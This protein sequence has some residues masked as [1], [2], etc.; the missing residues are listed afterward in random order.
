[1]QALR[2]GAASS[3]AVEAS[4]RAS[5]G[6]AHAARLNGVEPSLEVVT[7]DV[8]QALRDLK[9]AQRRFDVVV[10]D[11]P[12]FFPKR[13]G[14]GHALKA[15]RDVNVQA[16]TRVRD[17]GVLATFTCSAKLEREAF[18]ELVRS[19]ARECRRRLH[20]IRELAA[21]PDHPTVAAAPE[22]RYLTGLLAFV[23]G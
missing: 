2:R 17:G 8:R 21:G 15:Y 14:P 22:G 12:N 19:C 11:P 13:G 6:A 9:Q 1:M 18:F 20:V 10:C 23:H 3:L 4:S 7:A 5:K 16:L